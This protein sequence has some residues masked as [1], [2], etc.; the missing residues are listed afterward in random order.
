MIL[1][2]RSFLAAVS[3]FTASRAF[4]QVPAGTA[5]AP[6]ATA[7]TPPAPTSEPPAPANLLGKIIKVKLTTEAGDIVIDLYP[8][9]APITVA[10]WLRYVD[11]KRYDNSTFYRASHPPGNVDYG[12]IQGG[13]ENNPAKIFSP[14]KLEPTSKT[15]LKHLDGSISMG[16]LAPDSATSDYFICIGDS[17]Y[18]DSDPTKPGDNAGYA[19]FGRVVE[20]MDVVKKILASPTS[21]TLGKG[22]MK[23][24][25]L[26]PRIKLMTA[27]RVPT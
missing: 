12:I 1:L 13:L 7:Q 16:R 19:T 6:A 17:P 18:L 8:D 25:M 22:A 11:N 14:I 10:N 26:S 24:Q 3:A 21:P 2:R 9:K 15:G 27:R 5:P 20:G 4:A 23:G